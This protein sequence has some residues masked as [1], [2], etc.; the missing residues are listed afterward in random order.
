[1]ASSK[2]LTRFMIASITIVL[3]ASMIRGSPINGTSGSNNQLDALDSNTSHANNV[4]NC[5]TIGSS[6][7]VQRSPSVGFVGQEIN[8][9][10]TYPY[11]P[12]TK[13]GGRSRGCNAYCHS[14][15]AA[16]T[17]MSLS[18]KLFFSVLVSI[19]LAL[20]INLM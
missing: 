19:T 17:K 1:M 11:E 4:C 6:K 20:M 10:V 7:N 9:N 2:M 3:F 5:T 15:E 18:K 13:K 8:E 14:S 16:R 12:S